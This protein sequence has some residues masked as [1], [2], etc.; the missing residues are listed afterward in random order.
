MLANIRILKSGAR[1][2]A[3]ERHCGMI[4]DI[5]AITSHQRAQ[6]PHL[7]V[8]RGCRH[9]SRPDVDV[10]YRAA[11]MIVGAI[12]GGRPT[13]RR[14][15][16]LG[17]VLVMALAAIAQCAAPAAAE[18]VNFDVLKGTWFRPDGGYTIAIKSVD[19]NGQLEAMYFNPNQLPFA[20]AKG[21]K[22]GEILRV[23]FELRAGG[24]NGST[25]ELTYDPA[26]DRLKGIYYQAVAKQK[27]DVYFARK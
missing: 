24:Y 1:I 2:I 18:P 26:T 15:R 25:Y 9:R 10:A 3:Q 13:S 5:R 16:F 19:A 8:D 12:C 27:F 17:L 21:S 6:N 22:E 4:P 7:R 20:K 23:S 11:T 14:A